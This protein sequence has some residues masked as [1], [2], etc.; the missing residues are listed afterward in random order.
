M[1]LDTL[2]AISTSL[3]QKII[4][5]KTSTANV[6]AGLW[7][8]TTAGLGGLPAQMSAVGN[9][10][11]G[12]VPVA[13]D[14][15][16]P[17]IYPTSGTVKLISVEIT[18]VSTLGGRVFVYDRLFHAGAYT[19]NTANTTLASQPSFSGRLPNTDYSEALLFLECVSTLGLGTS[20]TVTIGYTN[21]AGTGSRSTSLTI[22][23]TGSST[24]TYWFAKMPMQAGDIGVQS[25][26]SITGSGTM[27][28]T[29]NIVVARPLFY[30][31][32]PPAESVIYPLDTLSA[33]ILYG[34][35]AL[36]IAFA[37][38]STAQSITGTEV[39]LEL[40]SG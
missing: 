3:R 36:G 14:T 37:L 19:M 17:S 33:P 35:S 30:G 24:G 4:F 38:D 28:N 20:A 9:T 27:A 12:L 18:N 13:G 23:S 1:A 25:V 5:R 16:F 39:V 8:A 26:D 22:N 21:E 11:N 34:T 7:H 2:N 10:A 40:A 31:Y 15:G 32:F 29:A 6:A